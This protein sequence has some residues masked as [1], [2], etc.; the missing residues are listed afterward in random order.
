MKLYCG[1]CGKECDWQTLDYG[2][3]SYEFWGARGVDTNLHTVSVCCE[4][5]LYLDADLEDAAEFNVD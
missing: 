3:G 5:D 1:E 2:I 4:G